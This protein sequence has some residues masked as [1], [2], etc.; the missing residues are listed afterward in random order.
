MGGLPRAWRV[1]RWPTFALS[2]LV[3]G[4]TAAAQSAPP[5]AVPLPFTRAEAIASAL[6]KSTRHTIARVDVASASARIA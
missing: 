1:N 4:P 5:L 6:E 2:L 3:L